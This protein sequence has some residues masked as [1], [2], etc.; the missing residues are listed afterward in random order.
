MTRTFFQPLLVV[1]MLLK[2]Q[3]CLNQ[4][5]EKENLIQSGH[6]QYFMRLFFFRQWKC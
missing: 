4:M 6:E 2:P 3:G 5:F 1:K